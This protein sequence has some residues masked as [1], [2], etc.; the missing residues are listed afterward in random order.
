MR[1][2]F[3]NGGR[4]CTDACWYGSGLRLDCRCI[5][6]GRSHGISRLYSPRSASTRPGRSA[7]VAMKGRRV[8]GIYTF[9]ALVGSRREADLVI[10]RASSAHGCCCYSR[11]RARRAAD[12][13][14]LYP[15]ALGVRLE[16][17]EYWFIFQ[18]EDAVSCH[19]CGLIWWSHE[20]VLG[21]HGYVCPAN[22]L[23]A[24]RKRGGMVYY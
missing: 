20:V 8:P 12:V 10:R 7:A 16:D 9:R 1:Q 19:D 14:L 4:A 23:A 13:G 3:F 2:D 15:E 22:Y 11:L 5:C 6:D 18:H 21:P 17:F 24:C